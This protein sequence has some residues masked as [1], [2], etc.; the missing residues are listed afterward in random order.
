MTAPDTLPPAVRTRELTPLAMPL[1]S[2]GTCCTASVP[3]AAYA[4]PKPMPWTALK[5]SMSYT[6][7]CESASHR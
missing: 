7:E 5:P 2:I 4:M 3:S 1:W 6:C